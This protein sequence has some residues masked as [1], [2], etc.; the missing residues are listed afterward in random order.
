MDDRRLDVG[1]LLLGRQFPGLLE[2]AQVVGVD[3]ECGD[4]V[5]NALVLD[6]LL[7][8]GDRLH[9]KL[10]DLAGAAANPALVGEPYV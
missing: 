6:R 10:P 8:Q 4:V 1:R 3:R 2:L 5:A 7:D 9:P